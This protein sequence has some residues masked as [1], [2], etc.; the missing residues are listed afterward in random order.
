MAPMTCIAQPKVVAEARKVEIPEGVVIQ[1][2]EDLRAILLPLGIE[3]TLVR[4]ALVITVPREVCSVP[5][6][7]MTNDVTSDPTLPRRAVTCP[8]CTTTEHRVIVVEW[9]ERT[10][11]IL[12]Q[13]SASGCKSAF[14]VINSPD[15]PANS[16]FKTVPDKDVA[17]SVAQK[18]WNRGSTFPFVCSLEVRVPGKEDPVP[19][20]D[21][22]CRDFREKIVEPFS[23]AGA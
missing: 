7:H 8:V 22:H 2:I 13:C 4:A 6:R 14:E 17:I 1:P 16:T 23:G 5:G 21:I 3:V 10:L 12:S 20:T 9:E 15:F 18:T 11:T 19:F